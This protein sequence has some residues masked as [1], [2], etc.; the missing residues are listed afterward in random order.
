[1]SEA[2]QTSSFVQAAEFFLISCPGPAL[3]Q[4]GLRLVAF[5]PVKGIPG[6]VT[7]ESSAPGQ[8]PP[9]PEE[10]HSVDG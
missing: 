10:I 8:A 6:L 3:A 9:P 5:Q 7:P 2:P 4:R 1:M